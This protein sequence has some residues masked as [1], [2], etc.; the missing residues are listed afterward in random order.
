MVAGSY[1]FQFTDK[2]LSSGIYIYRLQAGDFTLTKKMASSKINICIIKTPQIYGG[3][4]ISN[5][6]NYSVYIT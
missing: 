1:T 5:L 2:N 3:F 4:F 6:I